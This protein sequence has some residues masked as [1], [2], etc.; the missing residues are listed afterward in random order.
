MGGLEDHFGSYGIWEKNRSK[1]LVDALGREA[2]AGFLPFYDLGMDGLETVI[3]Q[4]LGGCA[5]GGDDNDE[6]I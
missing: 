4:T 6:E 3:L 5:G 1:I 2:G